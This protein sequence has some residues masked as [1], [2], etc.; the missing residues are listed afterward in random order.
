MQATTSQDKFLTVPIPRQF[1]MKDS[2]FHQFI[3]IKAILKQTLRIEVSY[4]EHEELDNGKYVATFTVTDWGII[5][6]SQLDTIRAK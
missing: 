2:D 1:V 5:N 6:A 4:K 3:N